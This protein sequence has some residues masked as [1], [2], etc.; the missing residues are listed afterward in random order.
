M[1]FQAKVL[2]ANMGV[3]FLTIDADS[4]EEAQRFVETSGA[5][6]LQMTQQGTSW[7]QITRPKAF[8]LTVFN[9]Q[10][11]TLLEAGQT[12]VDAIDVLGKNDQRSRHRATPRHRS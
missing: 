10:L 12:I 6:L 7:R 11:F 9:Q 3:E 2:N 5:R 4:R 1:R 8:N